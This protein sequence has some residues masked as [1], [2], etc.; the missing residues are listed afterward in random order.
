AGRR[1]RRVPATSSRPPGRPDACPGA[2]R[3]HQ[4]ADGGL[5]RVR[6]PGGLLRPAQWTA[7]RRAALDLG[8][9]HLELTSRANVQVRGLLPG[10]ESGLARRLAAVGLLP[11]PSHER[12]RNIVASPLTGLDGR[13]RWDARP[14]VEALDRGLCADPALAGLP[15]RFLFAVD[16]GRG[17]VVGA[18]ADVALLPLPCGSVAVLLAG[19]DLGLRT[20]AADAADAA[21]AALA[22]ARAFLAERPADG[23]EAWR[24]AELPGGPERVAARLAAAP[25]VRRG[26]GRPEPPT[27]PAGGPTDRAGAPTAEARPES[28]GPPWPSGAAG[29][30]GPVRQGDGRLALAVLAPLGRLTAAQAEAIG[31]AVTGPDGPRLTPW[32]GV[33]LP[34]V[35][36]EEA[37]RRLAELARCGLVTDA[38]S[39]WVGVTACTGAP[40]CAR[41]LADVRADAAA[42]V[43][44]VDRG[45]DRGL[46]RGRGEPAGDRGEPTGG[47]SPAPAAAPRPGATLLPVHWV[48]CERRCGHPGGRAVEVRATGAGYE[49][50]VAGQPVPPATAPPQANTAPP[51]TAR[52]A[53]QVTATTGRT[54]TGHTATAPATDAATLAAA[55][56]AARR[57]P[58]PGE[59]AR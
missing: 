57:G 53:P 51:Q 15:G 8:D 39:P 17:D 5:A 52:A 50:R 37:D 1:I 42:A 33:V 16:D 28:L 54:A 21:D 48:G 25:G 6:V 45:V 56:A 20:A 32:R 18:G 59:A 7:L 11:S 44:G 49:I 4:A 22:A 12:V 46:D 30:V 19:R 2:L 43:R 10:A 27:R 13:G 9:G 31:A 38:G 14:V 23:A 35:P 29:P 26:T 24:L 36:A 58:A 40:G 41:A 3:V 34:G 47:R 55:V